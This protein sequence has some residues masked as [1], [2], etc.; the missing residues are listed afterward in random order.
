[1]P[2]RCVKDSQ[3]FYFSGQSF[4]Q[5]IEKFRPYFLITQTLSLAHIFSSFRT[6]FLGKISDRPIVIC[7]RKI[8]IQVNRL[9]KIADG[10][11]VLTQNT[12]CS[13]AIGIRIGI[14]PIEREGFRKIADGLLMFS[15]PTQNTSTVIIRVGKIGVAGDCLSKILDSVFVIS[16]LN[17]RIAT[18]K[19]LNG[20]LI[21]REC[22]GWVRHLRERDRFCGGTSQSN[23]NHDADNPD[24]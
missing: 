23:Q 15:H 1:M 7:A 2:V 18:H 4:I 11:C 3:G 22:A 13:A 21:R 24:N 5:L 8:R 10:Q 14:S 16:G 20:H 6:F 12:V 9:G 19:P 17:I